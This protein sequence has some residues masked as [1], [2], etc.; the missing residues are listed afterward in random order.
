M[1]T[2]QTIVEFSLNFELNLKLKFSDFFSFLFCFLPER[3]FPKDG[4]IAND[5]EQATGV[6]REEVLALLAGKERFPVD[7]PF[8]H[9]GTKKNPAIVYSGYKTRIM[10]CVGKCERVEEPG[11]RVW[12]TLKTGEAGHC[13]ECGQYFVVKALP[14]ANLEEDP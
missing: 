6:E 7:G 14:G 12:W 13:P 4:Q 10:G 9:F 1:L 11:F 5:L 3:P 2:S 8:D